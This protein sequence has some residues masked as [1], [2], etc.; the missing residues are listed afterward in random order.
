MGEIDCGGN[1]LVLMGGTMLSKSLIEFSADGQDCVP[2][3][4]G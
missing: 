2:F 4:V 1:S 3:L